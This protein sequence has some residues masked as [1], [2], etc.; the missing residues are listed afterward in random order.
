[1]LKLSG[2][3]SVYYN[4]IPKGASPIRKERVRIQLTHDLIAFSD[5]IVDGESALL[6]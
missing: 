1:M 3:C 2:F 4:V 6:L 5:C